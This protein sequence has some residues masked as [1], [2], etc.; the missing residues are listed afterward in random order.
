MRHCEPR[1]G[2]AIHLLSAAYVTF[3]RFAALAM[4]ASAETM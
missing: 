2:A 1:S 4:T 3:D